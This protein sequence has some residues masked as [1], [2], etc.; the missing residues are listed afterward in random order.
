MICT[1]C[2]A[3]LQ[4]RTDLCPRCGIRVKDPTLDL[5]SG[6]YDVCLIVRVRLDPWAKHRKTN[7]HRY[8][9]VIGDTVL[10]EGPK[11][12][13]GDS[14]QYIDRMSWNRLLFVQELA[15]HG[16]EPLVMDGNGDVRLMRRRRRA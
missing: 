3:T 16:W 10:A 15:A 5:S 11:W 4:D 9:A 2:H 12:E 8:K 6:E 14:G 1:K 7:L 13:W